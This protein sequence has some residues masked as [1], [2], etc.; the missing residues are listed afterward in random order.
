MA[1]NSNQLV[2]PSDA[3]RSITVLEE[4][5]PADRFAFREAGEIEQALA[6]LDREL[7][8]EGDEQ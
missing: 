5:D 4:M 6:E 2:S 8:G 1:N 7:T 3:A